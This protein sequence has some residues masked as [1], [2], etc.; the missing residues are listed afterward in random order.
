MLMDPHPSQQHAVWQLQQEV[1]RLKARFKPTSPKKSGVDGEQ[2][3]CQHILVSCFTCTPHGDLVWLLS[4]PVIALVG[5]ALWCSILSSHTKALAPVQQWQKPE[6]PVEKPLQ[7]NPLRTTKRHP[8]ESPKCCHLPVP[9]KLNIFLLQRGLINNKWSANNKTFASWQWK[10]FIW[11]V[12]CDERMT[13]TKW[14]FEQEVL[15]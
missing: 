10:C 8:K 2:I 1:T 6:Y 5:S 15:F 9:R 12:F 4:P 11:I 14:V 13:T 7:R 3:R